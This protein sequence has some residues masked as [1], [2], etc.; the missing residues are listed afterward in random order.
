MTI[1]RD[2]DELQAR[3]MVRKFHGGVSVARTGNYEIPAS[4]RRKI[5][6]TRKRLL[7][8]AA[9]A[10]VEPGQA[11]LMDDSTTV[12]HMAPFLG[13]HDGLA[14]MTNY[15]PLADELI[16]AGEVLVRG[17]GG[18]YDHSHESFLGIGA[19]NAVRDIR[20]DLAFVSTSS[21]DKDGIYHQEERIVQLKSAMLSS[22]RR[23]ILLMDSS[24]LAASSM[25]RIGGWDCI[26]VLLTDDGAP[27]ELIAEL[28]T[29]GVTVQV[30]ATQSTENN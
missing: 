24:K 1:H 30:L 15:R 5:G 4:L 11:I 14:V 22:A 25:H 16:E 7:A 23:R 3:G 8:K 20:V 27:P 29:S 9:V 6:T 21:A 18:D 10:M 2:L 26:D 28:R 12:A 13:V 19:V 17:I